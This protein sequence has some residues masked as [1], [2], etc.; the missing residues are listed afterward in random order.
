MAD[1]ISSK[2]QQ[3]RTQ[4]PADSADDEKFFCAEMSQTEQ[5]TEVIFW[6]SRDKKQ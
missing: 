4:K 6:K 2:R 1:I 5:V 3:Y